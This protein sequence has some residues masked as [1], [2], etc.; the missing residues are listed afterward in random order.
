MWYE[1]LIQRIF[2]C[3]DFFSKKTKDFMMW[4]DETKRNNLLFPIFNNLDRSYIFWV[5]LTIFFSSDDKV[6]LYNI[7]LLLRPSYKLGVLGDGLNG[8]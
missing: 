7:L 8:P 6:I 2:E 1:G 5:D 3:G 4:L